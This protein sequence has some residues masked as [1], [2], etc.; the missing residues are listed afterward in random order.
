MLLTV[1]SISDM[2]PHGLDLIASDTHHSSWR[3]RVH[4]SLVTLDDLTTVEVRTEVGFDDVDET[5]IVLV[6]PSMMELAVLFLSLCRSRYGR[7]V[8]SI[9]TVI[10]YHH[11]R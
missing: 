9:A 7:L 5:V 10:C 3:A 4:G 2:F 6:E 11:G 1:G 8:V